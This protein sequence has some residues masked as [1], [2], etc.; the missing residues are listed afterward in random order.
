MREP[1]AEEAA[2]F[3]AAVADYEQNLPTTGQLYDANEELEA[4]LVAAKAVRD[5]DPERYQAAKHALRFARW[6]WR[7]IREL[8]V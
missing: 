1:T 4:E 2:A 7:S 3:C 6:Y 8:G 5:K